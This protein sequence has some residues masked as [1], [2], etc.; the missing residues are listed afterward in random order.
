MTMKYDAVIFDLD[1]TLTDSAPGIIA[2][3]CHAM[4]RMGLKIPEEPRMREYFLGPPVLTGLKNCYGLTGEAAHE[5]VRLFRDS[6]H[7]AGYLNNAVYPGIRQLLK[8]LKGAGAY[9]AVATAKPIIPTKMILKALDLE[10]FFDR[11]AGPLETDDPLIEKAAMIKR[12][13][14][15]G[16]CRAVM[17]GDRGS[18][19][20]S[21]RACGIP[22]IAAVYGYGS[23]D[24]LMKAEPEA[25]AESAEDLFELLGIEKP[26]KKGYFISFEGS[27][28]C[29]K[30]TQVRLLTQRLA[31]NGHDVLLTREPGGSAVGEQV[32]EILL[33]NANAGM[34][35]MTEAL[36]YAAARAQH[37]RE[38]IRPAL[39]AG[40]LVV[41]DRYV[42]SSL[43]YQGAGRELGVDVVRQVNA[44]AVDGL[45]PN[46]TV[47]L[48]LG[49]EE[50]TYR[51]RK[52]A[53]DRLELEDA[54]FHQRVAAA[55]EEIIR[56][57]PGRF[58][59]VDASGAKQQ[60][61]A[62]VYEAVMQRLTRDGQA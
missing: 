17:V 47:F 2:S 26:E 46:A 6:Y 52:R 35:N 21:A 5:T 22:G 60:T 36:L 33:S 42:D 58:I 19:L 40:R 56:D 50:A 45:M 12:V 3:L 15:E 14:P 48:A 8:A 30:S 28:G 41:S 59:V 31:Q 13:L 23:R 7:E 4:E 34:D 32:R 62:L 57:D 1:G 43:A 51:Q 18:D 24:E 44:P 29:G 10:R 11:V 38:V 20:L 39:R 37:V 16:E 54:S 9:L 27:D 61:A 55:Y 49:Q 53:K 25:V